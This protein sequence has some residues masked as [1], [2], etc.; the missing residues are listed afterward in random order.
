MK[1]ELDRNKGKPLS[2]EEM[3]KMLKF[4]QAVDQFER[5]RSQ[6]FISTHPEHYGYDPEKY[7]AAVVVERNGK[8]E[9][10]PTTNYPAAER[11]NFCPSILLFG[12]IY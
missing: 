8:T 6:K 1:R 9:V 2:D 3:E 4:S 10:F 11:I 5:G 7:S 12:R